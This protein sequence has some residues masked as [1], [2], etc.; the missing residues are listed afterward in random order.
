M[1]DD[2]MVC[3]GT[4]GTWNIRSIVAAPGPNRAYWNCGSKGAGGAGLKAKC[5]ANAEQDWSKYHRVAWV[6]QAS[7]LP[8]HH[9]LL[10]TNIGDV[11]SNY[12]LSLQNAV[13]KNVLAK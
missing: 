5:R 8:P 4:T 3:D 11:I 7:T 2:I 10:T 12:T 13:Q 1:D 6:A 9:K